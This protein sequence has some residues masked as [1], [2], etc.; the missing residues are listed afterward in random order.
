MPPRLS[1]KE[2]ETPRAAFDTAGA[3]RLRLEGELTE[4]SEQLHTA[5]V[6]KRKHGEDQA[7]SAATSER[8]RVDIAALV[9]SWRVSR[10]AARPTRRQRASARAADSKSAFP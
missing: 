8:L 2:S 1:A 9:A 6:D 4:G 3:A 5:L 10:L 7:S